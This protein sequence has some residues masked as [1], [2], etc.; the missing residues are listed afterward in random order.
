M[1]N[2]TNRI[3]IVASVTL[4][5]LLVIACFVVLRPFL[6]ALLWALILSMTTWRPYQW[7][8]ARLGGRRTLAASLM[9]LL[10]AS[11][12]LLPF[13]IAAPRLAQNVAAL[14][15]EGRVLLEEGP[16]EPP[17]WVAEIPVVGSRFHDYW[18]TAAADVDQLTDEVAIYVPAATTWLLGVLGSLGAGFLE[19][20]LSVLATFFFYRDGIA[21]ARR[22]RSVVHHV[23]GE[24]GERLLQV[25]G[26]TIKGVVYG[27]IGT[28]FA[29]GVLIGLGLWLA[30]VPAPFFLGLLACF[31]SILPAGAPVIWLPAAIWLFYEGETGWG[32]FMLLWGVLA[33]GS[34]D[35]FLKPYL[36]GRGSALPLLLVFLGMFGGAFA[37]GFLGLFLG[38][39]ILAIGQ[40]LLQAWTPETDQGPAA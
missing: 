39:T 24:R 35:N 32:A 30:G 23:A 17:A 37:F 11:A 36:I 40:S 38:P 14:A 7:L 31:V 2:R 29:Q 13:A 20:L 8:E 34:V 10:L 22:L 25:A 15:A 28:A 9:T 16:P 18:M 27:I 19:L 21:G 3:E 26:E 5:A 4:L 12:F 1:A 6:A 33:V